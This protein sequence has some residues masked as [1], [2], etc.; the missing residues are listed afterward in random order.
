MNMATPLS[1]SPLVLAVAVQSTT[2]SIATP[3]AT[4]TW[5]LIGAILDLRSAAEYTSQIPSDC[6]IT[7][8]TTGFAPGRVLVRIELNFQ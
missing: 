3:W 1:L 4:E 8:Q 5:Q 2:V 7:Y 6:Q